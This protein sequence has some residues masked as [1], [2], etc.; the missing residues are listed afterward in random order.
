MLMIGRTL[1]EIGDP[2]FDRSM[3]HPMIPELLS[4]SMDPW[5]NWHIVEPKRG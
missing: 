2:D 4:N 1:I 5:H 3:G